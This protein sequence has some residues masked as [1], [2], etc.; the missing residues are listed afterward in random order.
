MLTT[1]QKSHFD[2]FG[3]IIIRE[4]FSPDEMTA[5]SR[6]FDNVLDEDRKGQPFGGEMRQAVGA[7]AEMRPLLMKLIV[8]DRIHE[9][10][11]QLL[12]QDFIWWAA[13]G[14]LYVGDTAWHPDASEI[15]LGYDRIKVAFYLDPVDKDTGC[16]RFIPGSHTQPLHGDLKPLR[17]WRVKQNVRDGRV[18]AGALQPFLDQGLDPEKPLFGVEAQDLPSYPAESLPGDVVF[19]NQHLYHASFGGQTGRRQFSLNYYAI[20]TTDEQVQLL[21]NQYENMAKTRDVMQYT[22]R[23]RAHE[24]SFLESDRPRIRRMVAKLLELGFE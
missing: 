18:P 14:S 9:P 20:P 15:E 12:G 8:D 1:E 11:A 19:F 6:E 4:L 3:F 21:R 17:Y 7:F 16:L 2:T 23:T 13:D 10:I 24:K 5:I 22:E